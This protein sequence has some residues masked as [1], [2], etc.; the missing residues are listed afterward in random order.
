MMPVL[1]ANCARAS[2]L[3]LL[4]LLLAPPVSAIARDEILNH[5]LHGR[6]LIC[7]YRSL[8]WESEGRPYTV[9]VRGEKVG[10]LSI[11]S[12]LH[13]LAEPGRHIVFVEAD[14]NVSRSF[15]LQSGG[16][17]YIQVAHRRG[18]GLSHPKLLP[19]DAA[20]GMQELGRLSYAGPDFSSD[21]RQ[22]CLRNAAF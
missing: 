16:I 13:H 11:G 18:R 8:D 20:K 7:F 4:M 6:A 1:S 5:G 14:V 9:R 19:V 12:F 17:Y 10:G 21:S 2:I 3:T 15:E 22:Y